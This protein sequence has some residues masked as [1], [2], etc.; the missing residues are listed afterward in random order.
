MDLSEELE[1]LITKTL[2]ESKKKKRLLELLK[3][4]RADFKLELICLVSKRNKLD[5][6][7]IYQLID[8]NWDK[9]MDKL[10]DDNYLDSIQKEIQADELEYYPFEFKE[11]V[12]LNAYRL[13]LKSLA[14]KSPYLQED[15][16]EALNQI[17]FNC[18]EKTFSKKNSD[19]LKQLQK[20]LYRSRNK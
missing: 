10:S 9:F 8:C 17:D 20:L 18:Q 14:K 15:I 12:S 6:D 5:V 4:D 16:L 13:Y 2:I 11:G 3:N 19:S 1:L 7:V